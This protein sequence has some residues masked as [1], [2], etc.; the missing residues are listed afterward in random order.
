M[1]P[2]I[3]ITHLCDIDMLSAHPLSTTPNPLDRTLR[4]G[5][6]VHYDIRKPMQEGFKRAAWQQINGTPALNV[7]T[8]KIR[9]ISKAFPWP[10][11]IHAP[12]G[13][14]VTCGAIFEE[15]HK[16]LQRHIEDG[17]WAIVAVDKTRKKAIEKAAKSRQEK[18]KDSRLKRVDWLGDTPMFEGLEKDIEFER[19]TF[20]PG[21]A[22]VA[23]TWVARFGKQRR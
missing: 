7:A 23:E 12:A 5:S 16:Q 8:Y 21:S 6:G 2:S 4:V 10:C 14:V 18:D 1:C 22:S 9:I 17:E 19:K 3:C 15:L 11:V 13:S 20:L